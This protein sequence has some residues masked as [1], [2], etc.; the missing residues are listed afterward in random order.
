MAANV[1]ND[2]KN[3]TVTVD[4]KNTGKVAGKEVV[5]LYVTAPSGKLDK[6]AQELK[7]YAKTKALNAGESQTV[8]L[9][10]AVADL[11]SFCEAESAWVVEAGAYQLHI[12]ASSRDIRAELTTEVAAQSTKVSNV[13]KTGAFL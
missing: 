9:T 1:M 7:A 12:G 3:I 8:T 4:V 10:V 11:A 6:P 13:L 2:G 5:E